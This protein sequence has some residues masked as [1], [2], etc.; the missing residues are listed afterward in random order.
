MKSTNFINIVSPQLLQQGKDLF[1]SPICVYSEAATL[2]LTLAGFSLT[3]I[4]IP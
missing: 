2:K 3:P 1:F 4:L